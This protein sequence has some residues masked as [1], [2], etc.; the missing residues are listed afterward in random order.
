MRKRLWLVIG[1]LAAASVLVLALLAGSQPRQFGFL[2]GNVRVA[3]HQ[4]G[5]TYTTVGSKS[6]LVAPVSLTP[7]PTTTDTRIHTQIY[8]FQADWRDVQAQAAEETKPLGFV[9]AGS[10]ANLVILRKPPDDSIQIHKDVCVTT[11]GA[12]YQSR[13]GWVVVQVIGKGEESLLE[14]VKSWIGLK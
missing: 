12:A 11:P 4:M 7:P 14:R 6:P 9:V 1:G 2:K 3:E 8:S 10:N 13:K 5:V